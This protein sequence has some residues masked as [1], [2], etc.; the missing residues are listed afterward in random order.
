MAFAIVVFV[1]ALG[2]IATE[3]VDRT[4]VALLGAT[5]L[6]LRGHLTQEEASRRSTSTRSACSSG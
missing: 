3:R 4:N 1:V 2:V 6:L 5:L